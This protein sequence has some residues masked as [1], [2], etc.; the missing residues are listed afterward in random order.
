MMSQLLLLDLCSDTMK[1]VGLIIAT[2]NT[3]DFPQKVA[4]WKGN[5]LISGISR[6]VKYYFIWPDTQQSG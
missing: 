1:L 3:T 6:L 5:P 2:E 4:F